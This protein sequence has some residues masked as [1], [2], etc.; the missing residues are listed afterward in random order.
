MPRAS[1]QVR[2]VGARDE[3]EARDGRRQQLERGA[4]LAVDLIGERLEAASGR[5]GGRTDGGEPWGYQID[6][7][8][9]GVERRARLEPA[10]QL[11]HAEIR[12]VVRERGPVQEQVGVARRC[13]CGH[14]ANDGDRRACRR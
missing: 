7:G 1:A 10:D 13:A 9:R 11:Q 3:Q 8:A 2:H 14:H 5:F 4:D 6:F 12:R